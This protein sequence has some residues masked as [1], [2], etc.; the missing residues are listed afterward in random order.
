MRISKKTTTTFLMTLTLCAALLISSCGIFDGK[1]DGKE[2][3]AVVLDF[4]DSIADG[5]YAEDDYKSKHSSDKSFSK[6][7]FEEEDAEQLMTLGFEKIKYEIISS[8]GD[9]KDEEGTCEITLTAIDLEKILKEYEDGYEYET[10]KDAIKA[11]KAPT[12]EF[13]IVLELEYDGEEWVISDLSGL[14]DILGKPYAELS[15][16]VP[17]PDPQ[18]VAEQLLEA[19]RNADFSAVESLTGG[20]YSESDFLQEEWVTA[21]DLFDC[22]F[23]SMS[24]EIGEV[25]DNSGTECSVPVQI[26]YEDY[27]SAGIAVYNDTAVLIETV[28]PFVLSIALND[29][30]VATFG[31]YMDSMTGAIIRVIGTL[32]QKTSVDETVEMIFNETSRTW[33]VTYVPE[34]LLACSEFAYYIDPLNCPLF[35]IDTERVDEIFFTAADELLADGSI[36]QKQYD[37]MVH[38]SGTGDN[39]EYTKESVEAAIDEQGWV[40]YDTS[41]FV[42]SYGPNTTDI[43]YMI[44]FN[45]SMPGLTLCTE[46]FM[47]NG[48]VSVYADEFTMAA[49]ED[50]ADTGI[51]LAS[52]FPKDTYRVVISLPDGTVLVDESVYVTD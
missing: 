7:K 30:D 18:E 37:D 11:K 32:G 1:N 43:G 44:L 52:F 38:F 12:D 35:E 4:L 47:T 6:I 16:K 22:I 13:E 46:Y 50:Y 2:I 34:T 29:D 42:S 9:R 23:G 49:D 36:T 45:Q 39:G 51:T 24:W 48:T 5:T 25:P 33:M 14:S 40:D 28:K 20:L 31:K 17:V 3:E 8:E 19:V 15:F 41:T 10:L 27:Y 26:F 21:K